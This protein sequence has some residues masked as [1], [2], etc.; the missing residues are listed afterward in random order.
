MKSHRKEK[1]NPVGVQS[2]GVQQGGIYSKVMWCDSVMVPSSFRFCPAL[3]GF[4]EFD[5]GFLIV[6]LQPLE[7]PGHLGGFA[8]MAQDGVAK[9]YGLSVVHQLGTQANS[10]QG[11]RTHLVLRAGET[12][13]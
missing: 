8:E 12:F 2:E 9:S 6:D 11:R 1:G 13:E 4:Q 5:E 10:P 3:K 7:T